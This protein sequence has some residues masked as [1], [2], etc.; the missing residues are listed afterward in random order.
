M[1]FLVYSGTMFKNTGGV[2]YNDD[3]FYVNATTESD[4]NDDT[5]LMDHS[6]LELIQ[7]I[8][9]SFQTDSTINLISNISNNTNNNNSTTNQIDK[10]N[11]KIGKI[12]ITHL[13]SSISS[14]SSTSMS[15]SLRKMCFV[16]FFSLLIFITVFGNTLVIV[17][18]ITTRRLRTV[19][20]CFVMSLAVADWMV[21][22][23]VMP[24]AV[25]LYIHGR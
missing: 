5:T 16:I 3:I 11:E 7:E 6:A 10:I 17:S 8:I 2:Q 25:L 23:F 15:L 22:I 14:T 4:P 18:V 20:N 12:N 13:M 24:P 9:I 1:Q 19:T 21:G